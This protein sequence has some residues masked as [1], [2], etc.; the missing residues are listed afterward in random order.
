M[1]IKA[2]ASVI[3]PLWWW[4]GSWSLFFR[5]VS[6]VVTHLYT[7]PS[8]STLHNRSRRHRVFYKLL[9]SILYNMKTWIMVKSI[10]VSVRCL[11]LII[12][13]TPGKLSQLQAHDVIILIFLQYSTLKIMTG[14][15]KFAIRWEVYK[16]DSLLFAWHLPSACPTNDLL[17]PCKHKSTRCQSNFLRYLT[18]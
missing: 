15:E 5:W 14:T 18:F 11:L 16:D 6:H 1:Y 17:W 8:E 13:L 3:S 12:Y 9:P 4:D 7:Y 2:T 10:R